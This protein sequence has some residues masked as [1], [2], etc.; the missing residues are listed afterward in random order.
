[1]YDYELGV[2]V[3]VEYKIKSI[4]DEFFSDDNL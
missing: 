2:E 1:M 4:I 3:Q